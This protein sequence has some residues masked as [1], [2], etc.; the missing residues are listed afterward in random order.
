MSSG[1]IIEVI[2]PVVDVEFSLDQPLPDIIM[3]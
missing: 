1:K 3:H 2:G